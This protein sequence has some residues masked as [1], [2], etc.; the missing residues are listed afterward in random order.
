MHP[1]L[2]A[3]LLANLAMAAACPRRDH[4]AYLADCV[5]RHLQAHPERAPH[6]PWSIRA[7]IGTLS[8]AT[9]DGPLEFVSAA[10]PV[11]PPPLAERA[12]LLAKAL[13]RWTSQGLPVAV[14]D[15]LARRRAACEACVHRA[16]P[17]LANGWLGSCRLCGCTG[18]KLHLAT[19]HCPDTPPRW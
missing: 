11:H 5:V 9:L 7:G 15:E 13:A 17:A 14:P 4:P 12:A 19:E 1:P 16:P 3:E 10:V 6:G 2:P 18:A 8:R